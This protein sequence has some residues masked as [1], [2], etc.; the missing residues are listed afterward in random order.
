MCRR[1]E[2]QHLQF[3]SGHSRQAFAV[4]R[5][6][7]A[8]AALGAAV[9]SLGVSSAA[10]AAQIYWDGTNNPGLWSAVANWSTVS[11]GTTDPAAV[12]VAADNAIFSSTVV[13]ATA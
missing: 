3:A 10:S 13:G 1:V 5:R 7:R 12:P 2:V 8:V 11:N 4:R 9:A 6:A